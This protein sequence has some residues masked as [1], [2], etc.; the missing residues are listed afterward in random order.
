MFFRLIYLIVFLALIVIHPRVLVA[1]YSPGVP[2]TTICPV[3]EMKSL[4]V[5]EDE[6]IIDKYGWGTVSWSVFL[7]D[8]VVYA[9]NTFF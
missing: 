9:V 8:K 4:P 2:D 7:K 5:P 1:Y 3:S 6:K